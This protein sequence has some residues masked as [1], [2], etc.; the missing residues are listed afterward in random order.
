[1]QF[2]MIIK[3]FLKFRS[4]WEVWY[5]FSVAKKAN[6]KWFISYTNE[7]EMWPFENEKNWIEIFLGTIMENLNTSAL[8]KKS[9]NPAIK[10]L[11]L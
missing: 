2:C 6:F 4:T 9:I 10:S 5:F 3:T 7:N 1:M 8:K 11:P